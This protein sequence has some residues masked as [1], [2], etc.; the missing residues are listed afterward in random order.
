M[1]YLNGV[2]ELFSSG[3]YL[4]AD[5]MNLVLI[6]LCSGVGVLMGAL[7]GVT[8]TMALVVFTPLTFTMDPGPAF[9]VLMGIYVGSVFGGSISAIC[10]SIPG[11]PASIGTMLD[12]YPMT[13]RG[14]AGRAVSLAT[15]SS[16]SGNLI[17]FVILLFTCTLLAKAVTMFSSF[18]M[19]AVAFLGISIVSFI[20]EGPVVYGFISA[21]IGLLLATVGLDVVTGV[22]RFTGGSLSAMGGLSDIPIMIG[23]FGIVEILSYFSKQLNI[24]PIQNLKMEIGKSLNIM[25]QNKINILRSGIIGT[26]IGIIPAAA[27]SMA[28][29]TAYGIAKSASK[30]S[31]KFG[32]GHAPGI[33][34]C[35]TSNNASVGG[36][37]L[38]MMT[39]GIPGDPMSAVLI[40]AL[41]I[42]GLNP[43]PQLFTE[44]P[45]VVSSILL[46]LIIASMCILI[47]GILGGNLFA[48]VLSIPTYY[49]YPVIVVLCMTGA[50]VTQHSFFDVWVMVV[51]GVIGFFLVQLKISTLPLVLGL[52][53][54]TMVEDNFR[55]ILIL[56]SREPG[57]IFHHPIAL[58]FLGI[59]IAFL[60]VGSVRQHKINKQETSATNN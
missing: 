9:L 3:A 39:L 6:L 25:M 38:P 56:S 41:M 14:E 29:V 4:L 48:R 24:R 20:S 36:A 51:C 13:L 32:T 33:I 19:C 45:V 21:V 15:F 37:M 30:N 28:G 35:E 43:G 18:E 60:I 1:E 22:S 46:G 23:L 31:E 49:L 58:V 11:T 26:I 10:L 27:A 12:G 47:W 59:G 52:I 7:P 54:G 16:S 55:R 5:P 42:H 2:W 40:G 57:A 44:T 53:L 8:S 17:G 50:F 34:A